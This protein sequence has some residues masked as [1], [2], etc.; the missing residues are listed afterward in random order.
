VWWSVQIEGGALPLV[1]VRL[2]K[3]IS[4]DK[5]F[6]VMAVIKK[7]RLQAP[8]CIGQVAIANVLGLGCDVIV[9]KH[10]AEEAFETSMGNS[11]KIL[12]KSGK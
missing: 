4:K 5:I 9:T 7:T 10:V 12:S 8:V 3:H 2:S 6:A 11:G 1:S